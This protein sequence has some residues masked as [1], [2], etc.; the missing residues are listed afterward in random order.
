MKVLVVEDDPRYS[1]IWTD[2]LSCH[3]GIQVM[4]AASQEAAERYYGA[5]SDLDLVIMDGRVPKGGRQSTTLELTRKMRAERPKLRIIAASG[6]EA[7]QDQLMEAGCAARLGKRG[8][9]SQ[10]VA[11]LL[12]SARR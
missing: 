6:D 3:D 8:I 12:V 1:D 2:Y 9:N 4:L 11:A 10:T 7:L 5:H